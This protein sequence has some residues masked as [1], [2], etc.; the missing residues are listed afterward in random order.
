[1]TGEGKQAR[2]T[3]CVTSKKLGSEHASAAPA[4][5]LNTPNVA[6]LLQAACSIKKNPHRKILSRYQLRRS[7][8]CS[9]S[10]NGGST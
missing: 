10:D 1:M 8:L 2:L 3:I 7:F 5:A 6:K 9:K 4:S